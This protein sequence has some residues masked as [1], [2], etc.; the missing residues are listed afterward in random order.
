M[1]NNGYSIC[2]IRDGGSVEHRN[3]NPNVINTFFSIIN[4]KKIQQIFSK[5]EILINQYTLSNEFNDDL[6]KLKYDYDKESIYEPYYSF[7]LWLR[8]KGEIFL[9]LDTVMLD[10][11]TDKITNLVKDQNGNVLLYHTW[12][13]RSYGKNDKH[14][15]RIDKI[16]NQ[17][18]SSQLEVRTSRIFKDNYFV[19]KKL[20]RKNITL[21]KLRVD[22]ILS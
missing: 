6:T 1:S 10:E 7:Y 18:R 9:F 14:T 15:M 5:K 22:K 3:Y 20:A 11:P 4:F 16:L 2:G 13:A 21:L 12:Y 19:F 17:L 8:R